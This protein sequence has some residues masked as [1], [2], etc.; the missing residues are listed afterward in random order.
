M[1]SA[2][3]LS[4]LRSSMQENGLNGYLVPHADE[5]QGEYTPNCAERLA[6]LTGFSGSAGFAV[7]LD[8]MAVVMS[9]G[10]YTIQLENQVDGK[11]FTLENS[12]EIKM[13]EWI[14]EHAPKGDVIGYDPKL[15]TALEIEKLEKAGV[16]LVAV[17]ENLIDQIWDNQPAFPSSEIFLFSDKIAGRT[18]QEKIELIA[19]KLV[20]EKADAIV[21]TMSDSIAWLLNI[22][23]TDVPHIPI[24]LSYVIIHADARV[25]WFVDVGRLTVDAVNQLKKFVDILPPSELVNQLEY[26]GKNEASVGIDP[27]RSS[28]WFQNKLSEHGAKI[29]IFDDPCILP[30]A[31]KTNAEQAAMR[32]AH[33]RD[34]VALVKFLKWFEENA[35]SEK[36]TELSVEEKLEEFR[37]LV[38][39]F[40]EPSFSTIAGYGANGAIVHYRAD[41]QSSATIELDNLLLLDSGA[42]YI[43]G[44]TD[45]TRTLPVGEVSDEIKRSFTLVLKGHIA[46]AMAEFE[47]GTLGAEL[48]KLARAPLQA[49]GKDYSH[50][51]GHGVGCY[52]SVH[53]EAAHISPRGLEPL[54]A[55]MI[56]S[57]EPGYYETGEYGIR[58]ENLVL[59]QKNA[60]D[61]LFFETITLAPISTDLIVSDMLSET[62]TEWLN[63]YH[64]RVL[65]TLSPLLDEVEKVWLTAATQEV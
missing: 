21:L 38:P 8:D 42:Q 16:Q 6:W 7:V 28:I 59:V 45:I 36:L 47:E 25:Q 4:K 53:E 49:E 39:E 46:L 40:K 50:G 64:A 17:E 34:G 52:L 26:L 11:V 14:S 41:A 48:D 37:A 10:R 63:N 19:S 20:Q 54:R 30:R 18:A 56:I 33:V 9:D 1:N 5:Y 2:E 24:I 58:I 13:E 32:E 44:T 61:N 22:R 35:P 15:H 12:Q 27:K 31:C 60:N 62:E 3:K 51:T 29:V 23:G 57:N 43:D 65:K 55:G